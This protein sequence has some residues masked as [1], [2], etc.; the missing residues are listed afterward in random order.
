M[1]ADALGASIARPSAAV[2][3]TSSSTSK[4]FSY[5][6]HLNVEAIIENVNIFYVS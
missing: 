2:V 4:D 1:A 3:L 6:C 5:L